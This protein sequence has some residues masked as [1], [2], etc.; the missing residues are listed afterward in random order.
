MSILCSILR[1]VD[2]FLLTLYL[3]HEVKLPTKVG[4]QPSATQPIGVTQMTRKSG[5]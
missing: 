2:A 4:W 3:K 5:S 1:K